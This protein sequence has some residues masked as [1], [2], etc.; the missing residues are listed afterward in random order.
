MLIFNIKLKYTCNLYSKVLCVNILLHELIGLV[1][2]SHHAP[3][4]P[5][6]IGAVNY[7]YG[8]I[9]KTLTDPIGVKFKI[10]SFCIIDVAAAINGNKINFSAELEHRGIDQRKHHKAFYNLL[11]L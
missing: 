3:L 5:Y 7:S 1:L 6:W 4:L 2:V 9:L 11:T 8:C 10:C